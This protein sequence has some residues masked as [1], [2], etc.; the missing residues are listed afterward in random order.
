MSNITDVFDLKEFER[1]LEERYVKV[2]QHPELA[3]RI[4]NYTPH[5]QY[6][7]VWND[8]TRQCRGLITDNDGNIVARPFSKFFNLEENSLII[9]TG[10]IHVT[11][12]LDGSLGI[13]YPTS[14]GVY[15]IATRGSF[16]SDQA[17]HASN[18][19]DLQ[20]ADKCTLNPAWTYLCEIIYPT[21]RI[22]IDYMGKDELILLG[23]VDIATGQSIPLE[24]SRATWS[25]P[26]VDTHAYA[27]VE[28]LLEAQPRDNAEGFVVQFL[29]EDLRIKVKYEEYV[30]LHRI[31][32]GMSE[33]R[34]WEALSEGI[35]IEQWLD[36]VPDEFYTFVSNCRNKLTSEHA[37]LTS[38]MQTKFAEVK[39]SMPENW[40]RRDFALAVMQLKS[41]YPLYLGLFTLLDDR[42][43]AP[44]IWDR[45]RPEHHLPLFGSNPEAE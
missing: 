19:W 12:K 22:V 9:P 7:R 37:R 8:V 38:E 32:T 23:A 43:V 41:T 40:I 20:Y 13:V 24:Q 39:Q 1:M 6:D 2:T 3:L 35:D 4:Y 14:P 31:L 34:V 26:V 27:S 17:I 15:K 11:E 42:E 45:L 30:R 25:G 33:R 44:M 10:E 28:E 16:N 18:L 36:N 5:A 29:K 21:N